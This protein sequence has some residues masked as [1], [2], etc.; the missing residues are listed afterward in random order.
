[1]LA[2]IHGDGVPPIFTLKDSEQYEI[3]GSRAGFGSKLI[4]LE[5]RKCNNET[6]EVPCAPFGENNSLL[7]EYLKQ[8]TIAFSQALAFI[9]YD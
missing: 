6:S 2:E 3:S 7:D 8:Y 5:V 9:E 4:S 1:M